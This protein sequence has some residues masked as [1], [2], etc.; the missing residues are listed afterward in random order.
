MSKLLFVFTIIIG[1]AQIPGLG[2][3]KKTPLHTKPFEPEKI[4]ELPKLTATIAKEKLGPIWDAHIC[5]DPE[6]FWV[7]SYGTKTEVRRRK[8][9][10]ARSIGLRCD[11]PGFRVWYVDGEASKGP[12]TVVWRVWP[13]GPYPKP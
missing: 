13:E 8:L 7:I 6:V 12:L 11:I 9:L 5:D 1:F 3:T 4:I 10:I 2:Q